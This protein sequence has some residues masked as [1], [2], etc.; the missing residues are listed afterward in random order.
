MPNL[1][2]ENEPGTAVPGFRLDVGTRLREVEKRFKNRAA[3]AEAAGVAKSTLQNWVEGK[4]DPSFEGLVRLSDAAGVSVEWLAT[5]HSPSERV[6]PSLD[7]DFVMIPRYE[8]ETSAGPG[9]L[10]AE[11]NVVDYMAFQ[12]G[13]V[14]H[15]LHADPQRLALITAVGDSMEPTIRAGD[16]LLV[17]IGINQVVDDAIYVIAMDDH[18]VVKRLQ[19]FFGGAVSV[20]SDNPTYAEQTLTAENLS[21]AYIAGRVRWIGRLV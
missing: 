3:A 21:Q 10:M 8:V 9:A 17:D 15:V 16:L 11:E 4:T 7:P 13:W 20:K 14:R 19:R 6:L 2:Q 5:G 1:E 18:L 12:A